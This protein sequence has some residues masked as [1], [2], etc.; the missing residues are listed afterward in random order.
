MAGPTHNRCTAASIVVVLAACLA[1]LVWAVEARPTR[2]TESVLLVVGFCPTAFSSAGAIVAVDPHTGN[3][4]IRGRFEWPEE[5]F[6][7]LFN[8][9]PTVTVDLATQQAMFDFTSDTGYFVEVSLAQHRISGKATPSDPF[10]TGFENF[11]YTD[12]GPFKK[13]LRGLS[14]TVTESGYCDDGCFRYG[15]MALSG[16]YSAGPTIPFKAILDDSHYFDPQAKRFWVQGSYDLREDGKRC[17]P[18]D[19]D[20]CL[21]QLNSETGALIS[22][23]GPTNWTAYKYFGTPNSNGD[24]LAW[25]EGF[26]HVCKHPYNDFAF[27]HVNLQAATARL[28]ACIP[29]NVTLHMDEW[30]SSFNADG[31]R[32]ATGSGNT[33][34]P[35][36]VAVF[37]VETGKL[38][39]NTALEGLGQK[40]LAYQKMFA[41][42]GLT[43]DT[44]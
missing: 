19:T 20:E 15:T 3:Y 17:A 28:V 12:T 42:W 5:I 41:V 10:F 44:I 18:N 11:V 7:C 30:I 22:A 14:A 24:V 39:L 23:K 27:A 29:R 2:G 43:F 4:T 8:Y 34:A 25:V 38:I 16:H 26:D 33:E 6:G 9:D 35:A 37:E 31:T 1:V 32:F 13:E 21:L 36:Q 40:L